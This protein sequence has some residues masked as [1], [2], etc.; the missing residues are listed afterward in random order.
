[1]YDLVQ[2]GSNSYYFQSP[3][4]I[5]LYTPD[6]QQ[7]YLID[8]GLDK[9]AGRKVRQTLERENLTL[10]AILNTHSNADH[11]GGNA[12]LQSQTNCRVFANGIEADF[13]RHPLLEPS[14]LY[15]GFP[16]RELRHKFLMAQPSQVLDMSDPTFPAEVEILPLPGHFFDMIGFRTPDNT[17]YLADCLSSEATLT[18]YGIPFLYDVQ[19][20]LDTLHVVETM[21]AACFVPA[22]TEPCEDIAPLARLNIEKTLEVADRL[23]TLCQEPKT[24]E[25]VLQAMMRQYGLRLNIEQYV[26]VGSTLR[27]YLAWLKDTG[28]LQFIFED[29]RMLWVRV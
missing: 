12:Y 16:C 9:D 24:F 7:A 6:H 11:I 26:L 15:G 21:N 19:A 29:E 28:K 14:F 22:H 25:Q 8:S 18:K 3:V 10:T 1:M 17:V 4:K 13:A 20:Y 5:G 23:L 27:S 2:V